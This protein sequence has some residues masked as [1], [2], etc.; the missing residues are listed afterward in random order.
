[1]KKQQINPPKMNIKFGRSGTTLTALSTCR[2][3][4][5]HAPST[6]RQH[7]RQR[8]LQETGQDSIIQDIDD[9][10]D[11]EKAKV[12]LTHFYPPGRKIEKTINI[13]LDEVRK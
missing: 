13:D 10:K 9:R 5:V 8:S 6:C 11:R 3:R 2:Q 4:P 12:K 7:R 1:M